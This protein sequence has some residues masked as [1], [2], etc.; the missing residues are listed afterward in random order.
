MKLIVTIETHEKEYIS[1]G[2]STL[3]KKIAKEVLAFVSGV[4]DE[5]GALL[6]NITF[7]R[8]EDLRRR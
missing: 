4:I 5:S 8:G 3:R 6:K 7:Q 2:H 1:G